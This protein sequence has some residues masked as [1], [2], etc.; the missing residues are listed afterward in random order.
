MDLLLQACPDAWVSVSSTTRDPRPGEIDGIHYRFMSD[1][2]FDNEIK[3]D[4][5]LE[6]AQVHDHKY[7][8][9][10]EAVERAI[11]EGKQVIL[12]IDVQGAQQVR[13]H[14]PQ[15][16]LIFIAPPSLQELER[17]LRQRATEPEEVIVRRM[18]TAKDEL[19][20]KMEYDI[21]LVN[22]D[23]DT[24]SSQLISYV[25][26]FANAKKDE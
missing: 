14:M 26:S 12:E 15:A 8:T 22:D 18:N 7:G 24:T 3:R 9:S 25:D 11:Q 17:R 4:G 23:L 16:H 2:D 6:W 13:K 10:R 1:E 5:F 19:L 21:Q 20:H